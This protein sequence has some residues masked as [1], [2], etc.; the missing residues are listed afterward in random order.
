MRPAVG[1]LPGS[2]AMQ[3]PISHR[4]SSGRSPSSAGLLTS[5]YISAALVPTPNGPCPRHANTSTAP[6][7]K[8]SLAGPR[9]RPRTCSGDRY[10][11]ENSAEPK[12]VSRS[13]LAVAAAQIP[14]SVSRARCSTSRTFMGLRF[15][16]TTPAACMARR[17]SAS[18]AASI[19]T[20]RMASGPC[21]WTHSASVGP[22]T[23]A[24]ASHGASP[25]RS[26]SI[27]GTTNVPVTLVAAATSAWNRVRNQ[28]SAASSA[29]ITRTSTVFPFA[30][31]PRN[32]CP[33]PS[34]RS[35]ST[36]A[37]GPAVRD[38]SDVSGAT[39]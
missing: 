26:A 10:S 38:S 30:E 4:R 18:P 13:P 8:M 35:S 12:S 31:R 22:V 36:S 34:S 24:V 14:K 32:T 2:L 6:R 17:P 39:T 11:G 28:G 16:C 7:L 25:S 27:T 29:A 33:S 20:D 21:S 3:S 1:R 15:W 19:G 9:S 23:C 37:Y 5:R